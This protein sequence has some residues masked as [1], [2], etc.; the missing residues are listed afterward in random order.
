MD[1][2]TLRHRSP[3]RDNQVLMRYGRRLVNRRL[4]S[5]GRNGRGVRAP[6]G[7]PKAEIALGCEELF[8]GK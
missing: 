2:R 4:K 6:A 3:D 8:Y 7:G 5:R 1:T